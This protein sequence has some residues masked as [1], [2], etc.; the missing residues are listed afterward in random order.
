MCCDV[1][2][3]GSDF[4]ISTRTVHRIKS[5]PRCKLTNKLITDRLHILTMDDEEC[6]IS[7][8]LNIFFV[9]YNILYNVNV[10]FIIADEEKKFNSDEEI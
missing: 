3:L 2:L 7:T 6:A 10:L 5:L 9:L 8:I 1:T 4:V